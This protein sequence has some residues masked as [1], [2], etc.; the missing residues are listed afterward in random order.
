MN[1]KLLFLC[2]GNYYRSR[3]A[4]ILFNVLAQNVELEWVAFSRGLAVTE[5]G[6]N[7]IGPIAPHARE[8]LAERGIE[9][10]AEPSYPIQVEEADFETSDLVVAVK[11][12]EHRPFMAQKFP[13]RVNEVEYWHIHDLII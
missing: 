8:G 12:S 7:N 2:T 6:L 13:H 9:I 1:K 10:E 3:F 5:Y 4:E 11:E